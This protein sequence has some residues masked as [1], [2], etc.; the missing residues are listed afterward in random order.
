MQRLAEMVAILGPPP[1]NFLNRTEA[2][3]QYFAANG[4]Y[5]L[6]VKIGHDTDATYKASGKDLWKY[7]PFHWSPPRKTSKATVNPHSFNL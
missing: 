1:E 7:Q 2:A 6:L 5:S 3:S 4:Q